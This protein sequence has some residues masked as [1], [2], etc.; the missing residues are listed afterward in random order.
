MSMGTKREV[1]WKVMAS[2]RISFWEG[3]ICGRAVV[4][5]H[6]TRPRGVSPALSKA[7]ESGPT[8]AHPG[9][10]RHARIVLFRLLSMKEGEYW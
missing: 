9:R 5:H 8:S 10:V 1:A 2:P 3:G 7:H 4:T 6:R